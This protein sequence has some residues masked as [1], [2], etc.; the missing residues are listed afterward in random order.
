M[1]LPETANPLSTSRKILMFIGLILFVVSGRFAFASLKNPDQ[2]QG[3]SNP[4][5][6]VMGVEVSLSR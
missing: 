1:D 6:S 4:Q 2:I 5:S 3:V